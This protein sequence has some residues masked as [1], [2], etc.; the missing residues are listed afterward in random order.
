MSLATLSEDSKLTFGEQPI[1][2]SG[3][4]KAVRRKRAS[5]PRFQEL[6]AELRVAIWKFAL[7]GD[8]RVIRPRFVKTRGWNVG[9]LA[10]PRVPP[11]NLFW[12]CREASAIS[13]PKSWVDLRKHILFFHLYDYKRLTYRPHGP[14]VSVLAMLLCPLSVYH[15]HQIALECDW[16]TG[17]KLKTTFIRFMVDCLKLTRLFLVISCDRPTQGVLDK[18]WSGTVQFHKDYSMFAG[19]SRPHPEVVIL[20]KRRNYDFRAGT[21]SVDSEAFFSNFTVVPY[22]PGH[23]A[24]IGSRG[25]LRSILPI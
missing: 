6:P 2:K 9:R 7:L 13:P 15:T 25:V 23:H 1:R 18:V 12:S 16:Q 4:R 11:P 20:L 10:M 8:S 22:K 14:V 17:V 24:K 3:P 19:D 21:G 5:F